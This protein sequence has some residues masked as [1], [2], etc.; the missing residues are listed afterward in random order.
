MVLHGIDFCAIEEYFFFSFSE[1]P[2]G[3]IGNGG[4]ACSIGNIVEDFE[5]GSS[6][7]VD[8]GLEYLLGGRIFD[9]EGVGYFVDGVERL[10]SLRRLL[11]RRRSNHIFVVIVK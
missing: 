2:D 5:R 11:K 8:K 4:I 9:G 3:C 7:V 6:G 1:I 10:K